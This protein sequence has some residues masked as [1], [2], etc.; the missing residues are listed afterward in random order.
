MARYTG[1]VCKICRRHGQ[2]LFLKG[3]KCLTD[4]CPVKKR[5]Y[6][7]GLHGQRRARK[8]SDF[9]QQLREKQRTR[10]IYGVLEKQF[11]K[12]FALADKQQ[13]PTG[14]N[15]LRVLEQRLDNVVF[16]LGF[17]E[18]R[19]QARQIV[20][21]GHFEVNGRKLDIPSALVRA[22]DV[23]SVRSHSRESEYFKVVA[24]T[25]ARKKQ[26]GWLSLDAVNMS[27][28]IMRMPRR[29]EVDMEIN[30]PLIVEFYSR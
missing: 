18:S 2:Q 28:K 27:G 17:A 4:K 8:V 29:D 24:D 30:E 6:P 5:P 19:P 13:G 26:P 20:T 11:R 10:R 12:E 14:E 21:H 23:I 7:P 15:M 16:R 22:G 1:P 25:L 9:G 3:E